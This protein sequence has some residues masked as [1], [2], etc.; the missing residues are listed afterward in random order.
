V[1]IFSSQ[2]DKSKQGLA[3]LNGAREMLAETEEVGTKVLSDLAIQ[4]E[5]IKRSTKTMKETN[6]EL[7]MAQKLANKMS[8]WWRA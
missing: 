5:V 7:S 3:K 4:K 2:V 8:R 1:I 6:Q